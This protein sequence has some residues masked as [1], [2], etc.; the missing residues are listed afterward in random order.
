MLFVLKIS[1][2]A[3]FGKRKSY[4]GKVWVES[5]LFIATSSCLAGVLLESLR[6]CI[7]RKVEGDSGD[8]MK[9]LRRRHSLGTGE[10][11]V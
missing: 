5:L 2:I 4:G 3:L 6:G 8:R 9:L 10:D 7:M 1:R 11:F